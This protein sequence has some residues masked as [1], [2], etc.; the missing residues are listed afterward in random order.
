ML[1]TRPKIA[2]NFI[3]SHITE[4]REVLTDFF[5]VDYMEWNHEQIIQLI[6]L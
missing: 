5:D 6:V 3:P 1:N 2:C 4:A